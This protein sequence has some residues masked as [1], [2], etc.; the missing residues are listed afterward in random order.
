M[1]FLFVENEPLNIA[2]IQQGGGGGRNGRSFFLLLKR[3]I[4]NT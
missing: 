1:D 2:S 4:K 3:C